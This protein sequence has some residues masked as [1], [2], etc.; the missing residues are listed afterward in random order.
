MSKLRK[1]LMN[2]QETQH[3]KGKFG[4]VEIDVSQA[5]YFQ[6]GLL[7]MPEAQNF[8]LTNIPKAPNLNYKI[9]QSLDDHNLSFITMP[10]HLQND[11]IEYKDIIAAAEMHEIPIK[12]LALL[13]LATI[14]SDEEANI[15]MTVNL[16]APLFIDSNLREGVQHVFLRKDYS[17]QYLIEV[18]S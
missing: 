17:L 7:G 11:Y 4:L 2:T 14:F 3:I 16:R 15:K 12:D 18:K 5:I 1:Q 9:L 6:R 13:L 10:M 8:C